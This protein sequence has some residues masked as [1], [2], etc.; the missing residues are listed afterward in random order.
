MAVGCGCGSLR[1][2]ELG[3]RQAGAFSQPGQEGL[4]FPAGEGSRRFLGQ[5]PSQGRVLKHQC[6][7]HLPTQGG[8]VLLPS[9]GKWLQPLQLGEKGFGLPGF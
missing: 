8:E 9:L 2:I 6:L 7:L 1:A 4:K 3:H 5:G